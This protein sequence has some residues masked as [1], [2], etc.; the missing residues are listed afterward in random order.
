MR[1]SAQMHLETH[2]GTRTCAHTALPSAHK[3]T[4]I[5][6][7][8]YKHFS[9][10]TLLYDYTD[11]HTHSPY[12]SVNTDSHLHTSWTKRQI[13]SHPPTPTQR[14]TA[15]A[16]TRSDRSPSLTSSALLAFKSPPDVSFPFRG[17]RKLN[18]IC[19]RGSLLDGESGEESGEE[20]QR[21]GKGV[22]SLPPLPQAFA[23]TEGLWGP[24]PFLQDAKGRAGQRVR[25]ELLP[26]EAVLW[27]GPLFP[28]SSPSRSPGAFGRIGKLN[29]QLH[30][31]SPYPA[32]V[33][34]FHFNEQVGSKCWQGKGRGTTP[35]PDAA[36]A[37]GWG[38]GSRGLG[39]Y[40][41][42]P[43]LGKSQSG[44]R[45]QKSHRQGQGGDERS[46]RGPGPRPPS[47]VTQQ[48]TVKQALALTPSKPTPHTTLAYT[49]AL[50]LST[51]Y[52]SL[53]APDTRAHRCT[54]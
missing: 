31:G 40:L 43:E 11:A 3:H 2:R 41:P 22:A 5:G 18:Q 42:A 33:A 1:P 52:P 28:H 34:E 39:S 37:R 36:G 35:L 13:H 7:W 50:H 53:G 4:Q 44:C 24:G 23:D 29:P 49:C 19:P 51:R 16:H 14:P 32:G 38:A 45:K 8:I 30:K 9:T 48:G 54:C 46:R 12:T 6:T 21:R 17:Q 10:H 26:V 27:R 25:R 47:R 15:A 20:V